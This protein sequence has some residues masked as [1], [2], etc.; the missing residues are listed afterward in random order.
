[1]PVP[2]GSV[3]HFHAEILGQERRKIYAVATAR[4]N[5]ADGPV[6]VIAHSIFIQVGVEHFL[7]NGDRSIDEDTTLAARGFEVNP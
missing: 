4:L 7:K 1:M 3:L 2:V 5:S 6:A